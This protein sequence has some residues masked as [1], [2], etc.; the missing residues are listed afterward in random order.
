MRRAGGDL[1]AA[2]NGSI[3]VLFAFSLLAL[4]SVV[5]ASI[6]LTTAFV[7][8]QKLSQV[9]VMA[10][11]YSNRTAI[12]Q[13]SISAGLTYTSQMNQFITA[14][15]TSQAFPF[16]QTNA[17]PFSFTSGG[18]AS[19]SLA[20]DVPT[21]FMKIARI[22]SVPV[23]VSM[24]CY[25]TP[26]VQTQPP[27]GTYVLQERFNTPITTGVGYTFY[28]RNGTQGIAYQFSP[29]G[30]SSTVAYTGSSGVKWYVTGYCMEQ[31][32]SGLTASASPDL[33]PVVELDCDNGF[34]SAGN[35]SISTPVVL[36]AGTYELRY[37]YN[38]RIYYNNY[39][40][41]YLCANAASDL[42]WANDT[43]TSGFWYVSR[44]NQ[45]N[46][47]FDQKTGATPPMHT[48]SDGTSLA[49]SNLIDMCVYSSDFVERSVKI[50]ITTGG[51][52]WLSFAADGS[53]DSYGGMINNVRLCSIACNGSLKDNF[54]SAWLSSSTLF[55]DTF[56]SVDTKDNGV[57]TGNQTADL[58]NSRASTPGWPDWNSSSGSVVNDWVVGQKNIVTL[59]SSSTGACPITS[60][61]C[62]ALNYSSPTTHISRPF[63]LVPGYYSVTYD[64]QASFTYPGVSG[65]YCGRT[66]SAASYSTLS[67][68]NYSNVPNR[69]RN[70]FKVSG[71]PADN[72]IAVFGWHP[73]LISTPTSASYQSNAKYNNPDGTQTSNPT[74]APNGISLSNYNSAQ[75]NPLLDICVFS[76]TSQS[77][78]AYIKIVKPAYYYITFASFSTA[79]NVSGAVSN[80]ALSAIGGVYGSAPS[81]VVTIPVP[82]PQSNATATFTG[83]TMLQNEFSP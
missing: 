16:A 12:V 53:N 67:S 50:T 58:E 61:N 44:T 42:S 73:G 21:H 83:F 46:V 35:S 33:M 79:N 17:T 82:N 77:R 14:N 37:F 66:P 38:A 49:G 39:D 60:Q 2:R 57:A 62:L 71:Y 80:V 15:L 59:W 1:L 36:S 10:C 29:S 26:N 56:N 23:S 5:G 48:S 25:S 11:Q 4:L 54:P 78:I 55:R 65:T 75:N 9:A 7:A 27:A 3:T 24:P 81:N 64:Y 13:N 76:S 34:G 74:Y 32:L 43:K 41:A 45:I 40:P 19:V 28:Q 47:Y 30:F 70:S 69:F 31:D 22:T 8:R 72:T 6:D 68:Q 63:L 20:A 51:T 52:Y 18:A